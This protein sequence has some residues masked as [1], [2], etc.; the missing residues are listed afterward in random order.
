MGLGKYHA[1]V[2]RERRDEITGTP[3]R[4]TEKKRGGSGNKQIRWE[5]K[6]SGGEKGRLCFPCSLVY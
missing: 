3:I 5:R 1:L 6:K 4:R 2:R